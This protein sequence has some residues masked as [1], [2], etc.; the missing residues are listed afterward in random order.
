MRDIMGKLQ[1]FGVMAA[2]IGV[3]G[4]T[5]AACGDNNSPTPANTTGPSAPTAAVQQNPPG[6]TTGGDTKGANSVNVVLKEWAIEPKQVGIPAGK[7]KFTVTNQGQYGHD[8]V[9]QGTDGKTKVFKSSDGPQTIEVD[10]KPGTY[11]WIC[12]LPQ[13]ADK[14]MKGEL[15]VK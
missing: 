2:L 14:G 11:T 15:D 9:I 3:M 12:D 6:T 4:V 8:L 7:V 13:H 10:L 5:L 1:K